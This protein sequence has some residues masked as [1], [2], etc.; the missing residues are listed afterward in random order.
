MH[1]KISSFYKACLFVSIYQAG[2]N[3][4]FLYFPFPGDFLKQ[5]KKSSGK[6]WN[7]SSP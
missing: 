4:N 6:A 3:Y 2:I 5:M 7:Y 1:P